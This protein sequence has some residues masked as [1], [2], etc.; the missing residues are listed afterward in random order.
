MDR[1]R[2]EKRG[3]EIEGERNTQT[4]TE[5]WIESERRKPRERERE[6]EMRRKDRDREKV[7]RKE[8]RHVRNDKG[9]TFKTMNPFSSF[10][11]LSSHIV[12][13]EHVT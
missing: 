10:V 6:R 2:D 1:G 5:R 9:S 4:E 12:D 8:G 11:S 13:F 3:K 7:G